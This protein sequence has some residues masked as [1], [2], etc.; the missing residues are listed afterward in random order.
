MSRL[1][2]KIIFISITSFFVV[3]ING[4]GEECSKKLTRDMDVLDTS[5]KELKNF[6]TKKKKAFY[7]NEISK[8]L[9]LTK[10]AWGKCQN[11]KY[12]KEQNGC[13][14]SDGRI[15]KHDETIRS[16]EEIEKLNKEIKDKFSGNS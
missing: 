3:S 16:C 1:L 7:K 13:K 11:V 12:Y 4:C 9:D 14:N 10:A 15:Y 6:D 2:K 5:F 8:I